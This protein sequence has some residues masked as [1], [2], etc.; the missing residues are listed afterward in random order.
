MRSHN[1]WALYSTT[2]FT[3]R[4]TFVSDFRCIQKAR[5]KK[6]FVCCKDS[7]HKIVH[8]FVSSVS[9]CRCPRVLYSPVLLPLTDHPLPFIAPPQ[10]LQEY[11]VCVIS[12]LS[13]L[14]DYDMS[15]IFPFYVTLLFQ[16][17]T[18]RWRTD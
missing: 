10:F 5:R 6:V 2:P 7:I 17:Q 4:V 16:P 1:N 11:L 18:K 14:D 13:L 15:S 8:S 3:G 9:N 12:F